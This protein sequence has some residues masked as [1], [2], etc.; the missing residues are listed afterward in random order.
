MNYSD[1][2]FIEI[3]K[4]ENY[5]RCLPHL[6]SRWLLYY[7]HWGYSADDIAQEFG[8]PTSTVTYVLRKNKVNTRHHDY[9]NQEFKGR[10]FQILSK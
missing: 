6:Q 3:T 2:V 8:V 5:C 4:D 9:R 1:V 7:V 10:F